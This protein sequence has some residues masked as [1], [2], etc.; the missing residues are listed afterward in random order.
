MNCV[1]KNFIVSFD[2]IEI[3]LIQRCKE[4]QKQPSLLLIVKFDVLYFLVF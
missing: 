4:N 1:V 2:K 3:L